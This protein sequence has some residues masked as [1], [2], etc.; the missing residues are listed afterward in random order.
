MT[1]QALIEKLQEMRSKAPHG[2]LT[3]LTELFGI[4][5]DKEIQD[6]GSNGAE[7]GRGANIGNVEINDG[8]QLAAYVDPKPEVLKRW[9]P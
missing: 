6:C 2:E 4:L 8:R 3:A 5:F 1:R 7:I 9:K